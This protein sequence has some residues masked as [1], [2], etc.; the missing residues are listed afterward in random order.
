[1]S[2]D[3]LHGCALRF[4]G[5]VRAVGLGAVAEVGDEGGE[6]APQRGGEAQ[7]FLGDG[8]REGEDGGV[9]GLA[10]EKGDLVRG[11]EGTSAVHVV[12][13]DGPAEMGEVNADLVGSACFEFE[14]DEREG[15]AGEDG[16]GFERCGS[17]RGGG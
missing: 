7:R 8:V 2:D 3:D 5:F 11:D 15:V 10:L 14:F 12:A 13:D 4:V 16:G 1:M 6:I 17:R 9:E